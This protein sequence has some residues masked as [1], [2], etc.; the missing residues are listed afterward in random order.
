MSNLGN[1]DKVKLALVHLLGELVHENLK[2]EEQ[3]A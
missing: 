2:A 3:P 1:F